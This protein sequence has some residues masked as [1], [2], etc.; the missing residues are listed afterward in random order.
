[1]ANGV[2]SWDPPLKDALKIV[3]VHAVVLY[4]GQ[5]LYWC[6]DQRAVGQINS[7]TNAFQTFF[8]DPNLGS[9]Q[10]WDPCSKKA[11]DVEAIGRNSFCAGQCTL[12]DGTVF[13]AGGQDQYGAIDQA[14]TFQSTLAGLFASVIGGS[15]EGAQ[16]DIHNY[17][18]NTDVWMRWPDM[19]D[20]RY[21]PSCLT[22][23]DGTAFVA[24]GLSNL[25]RWVLS[26]SN[27]G[28]ND[29]FETFTPGELLF[30]NPAQNFMSAD[31][32]P[33]LRL[34]P[35]SR[36][37]FVHI[38]NASYLFDLDSSSFISGAKFMPA[39]VGRQTYPMQTGHVLLPQKE[40]DP[41]RIMIVGG[42]TATFFNFVD[43][44]SDAPAV[45]DAFIF[46]YNA[47][48]PLDSH[49]RSTKNPP[50]AARLL[51][52]TVLLPD[53]KVFIVNGIKS[54]A[55]AG[56][57]GPPVGTAE[58]FDPANETFVQAASPSSMHPRSYHATAVLLP[59]A[60]VA[61]AGNT[62]AY[63]PGEGSNPTDDVSIEIYSPP[64]LSMGTRPATPASLPSSVDYGSTLTIANTAAPV[65]DKVM[66]MRP[67][68]V[69]HSVDMD[70]RAV[71]LVVTPANGGT[72]LNVAIPS[73]RSLAPPGPYMFFFLSKGIPSCASFIFVG[74]P[75][76]VKVPSGGGPSPD[77]SSGGP[78]PAVNLGTYDGNGTVNETEDGDV[79]IDNISE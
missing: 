46:E 16:K 63:N 18:P 76:P 58:L 27:W 57:S 66:M 78:Y 74:V 67:C 79:T 77:C 29:T 22:L 4:T 56:H 17:D 65:I 68:A 55:A 64:Y 47:A 12:K 32:Y 30:K 23:D 60:R 72:S 49:W 13:V 54:G 1:M 26:G 45:K 33:I 36:R 25:M 14:T 9:Y 6:F 61:I 41:P 50:L 52:D 7:G 15:D 59:D 40:G 73:D 2:G 48:T 10:I 75:A 3:G 24:G 51:A 44:Q 8:P 43:T 19:P 20:G 39:G 5:V 28:Q 38:D 37:L 34:L 35:G 42:S 62:A 53:G 71:Q 31:Q 11:G 21:Y 70:Q 69:T